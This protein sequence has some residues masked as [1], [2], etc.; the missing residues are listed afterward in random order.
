MTVSYDKLTDV[1]YVTYETLPPEKYIYVENTAG[2][3]LRLD[4]TSRRVVGVTIPAFVARCARGQ[5]VITEVGTVPFNAFVDDLL[6][7]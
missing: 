3:I 2:D 1:L 7:A 4:R 5:V 6:H